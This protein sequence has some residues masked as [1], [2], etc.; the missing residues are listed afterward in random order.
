MPKYRND[1]NLA[2]HIPIHM[3]AK[4]DS[5]FK[6]AHAPIAENTYDLSILI[7]KQCISNIVIS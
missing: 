7:R 6:I 1:P 2:I 4:T 3:N 5:I